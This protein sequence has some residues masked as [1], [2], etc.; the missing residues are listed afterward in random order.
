[1]NPVVKYTIAR[2]TLFVAVAAALFIVPIDVSP[3]LRLMIALLVSAVLSLVLLR[4]LRVEVAQH[5]AISTSR[6]AERREHLRA[7]LAGEDERGESPAGR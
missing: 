2:L 1:M 3:L 6:R 4:G 5:V 7:A